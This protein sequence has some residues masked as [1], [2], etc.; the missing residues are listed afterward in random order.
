MLRFFTSSRLAR[1]PD[2]YFEMDS[3]KSFG[4]LQ[5]LKE[6]GFQ[7]ERGKIHFKGKSIKVLAV[8]I[9][10]GLG[11]LVGGPAVGLGLGIMESL[12][13]GYLPGSWSDAI[14]FVVMLAVMLARP[15]GLFG[16]KL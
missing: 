11:S 2:L 13:L 7:V 9:I 10:A 6:V 1:N 12:V 8:S 5:A 14:A 15:K 16:I 4:A 3:S